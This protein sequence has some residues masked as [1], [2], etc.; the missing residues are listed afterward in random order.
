MGSALN[1]SRPRKTG[2]KKRRA[3]ENDVGEYT[4]LDRLLLPSKRSKRG[5]K[6]FGHIPIRPYKFGPD[7]IAKRGI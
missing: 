6:K 2:N 3:M 4:V 5:Y 7:R 1:K